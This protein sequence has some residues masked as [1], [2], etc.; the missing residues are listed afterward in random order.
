[1]IEEVMKNVEDGRLTADKLL[2]LIRIALTAELIDRREEDRL[3]QVVAF[4]VRRLLRGDEHLSCL[5]YGR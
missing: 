1:M 3:D 5:D 2:Q 4:V